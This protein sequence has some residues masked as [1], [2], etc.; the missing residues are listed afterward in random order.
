MAM[1]ER[2]GEGE[3]GICASSSAMRAAWAAMVALAAR[4]AFSAVVARCR[5]RRMSYFHG[6]DSVMSES[7]PGRPGPRAP[8]PIRTARRPAALRLG[9]DPP[10][11]RLAG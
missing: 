11:P 7:V 2:A 4:V 9:P 6:H 1:Y 5:R 8:A 3:R 10:T